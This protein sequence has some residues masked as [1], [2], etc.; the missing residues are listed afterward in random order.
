MRKMLHLPGRRYGRYA[1]LMG[2]SKQEVALGKGE[3][4]TREKSCF[5]ALC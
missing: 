3:T 5:R 1:R 4:A 2:I